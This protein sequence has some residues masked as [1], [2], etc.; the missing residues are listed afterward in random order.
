MYWFCKNNL[1]W[2]SAYL[3]FTV[4]A[5]LY[6]GPIRNRRWIAPDQGCDIS[7]VKSSIKINV[8]G[9]M[10][11]SSK[12]DLHFYKDNKSWCLH[13][14]TKKIYSKY[15]EVSQ[16]LFIII[17]DNASYHCRQQTKE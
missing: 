16:V 5:T 2:E 13:K 12:I 3:V 11:Y 4:E 6:G 9:A 10:C 15:R 7:T 8:W 14:Y 1:D 17:R